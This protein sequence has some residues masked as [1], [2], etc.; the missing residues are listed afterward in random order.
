[1]DVVVEVRWWSFLIPLAFTLAAC[2]LPFGS[3]EGGILSSI[4]GEATPT[5][6]PLPSNR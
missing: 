4:G 2:A 1:M 6:L 3:V 5:S